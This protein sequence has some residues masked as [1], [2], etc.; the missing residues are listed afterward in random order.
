MSA[1]HKLTHR[2]E[3]WPSPEILSLQR[4]VSCRLTNIF[5]SPSVTNCPNTMMRCCMPM[6]SGSG[7]KGRGTGV[8]NHCP[9][10]CL[11]STCCTPRLS[12]CGKMGGL[13]N[14]RRSGPCLPCQMKFIKATKGHHRWFCDAIQVS[15][16][17]GTLAVIKWKNYVS[18]L[19]SL[20]HC[21]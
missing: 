19:V 2:A 5:R 21:T 17:F 15:I 4:A 12:K 1:L 3:R 13:P 6:E 10:W 7:L 8:D 16:D 11:P 18:A 14:H 20:G 9:G